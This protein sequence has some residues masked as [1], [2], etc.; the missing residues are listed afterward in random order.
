MLTVHKK[1]KFGARKA[2]AI[3]LL[4]RLVIVFAR[5]CHKLEGMAEVER[6]AA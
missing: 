6:L 5:R 1:W 4:L 3:G 2:K